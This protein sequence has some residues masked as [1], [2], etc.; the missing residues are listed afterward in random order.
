MK[1]NLMEKQGRGI[2]YDLGKGKYGLA[3]Y[4]EQKP[5][6]TN[7]SRVFMRVFKDPEC[8]IPDIDPVSGKKYVNLKHISQLKQIGFTD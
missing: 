5:A 2:I 4:T 7:Y 8:T 1:Y 3:L 6:F